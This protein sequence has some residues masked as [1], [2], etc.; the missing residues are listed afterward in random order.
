MSK[1][2]RI[3]TGLQWLRIGTCDGAVKSG[4]WA[5]RSVNQALE[6]NKAI[7]LIDPTPTGDANVDRVAAFDASRSKALSGWGLDQ[8]LASSSH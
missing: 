4:A 2:S 8:A 1:R 5:A 3:V 6:R 7:A